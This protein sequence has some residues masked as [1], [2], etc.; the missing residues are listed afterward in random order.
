[1]S[2]EEPAATVGALASRLPFFWRA[3]PEI[4]FVQIEAHF[5]RRGITSQRTKFEDVIS[6]L[7]PE[8][9]VEVR[10]I[11]LNPPEEEPYDMLKNQL[12]HQVAAAESQ[13]IQQLL[14]A[15]ELG[16]RK[17]TQLLRK[18]Q[19]LLGGNGRNAG[20]L[21]RELFLQRLPANVRMVLAAAHESTSVEKLAEMADRVVE[22]MSPTVSA[23]GTS[24]AAGQQH[25]T[26]QDFTRREDHSWAH[27]RTASW[28]TSS[29]PWI[30][31]SR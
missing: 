26:Q 14:T 29:R 20:T 27:P 10:D 19:Q 15:E 5:A 16:D 12:I 7:A 11:L 6:S 2:L 22:M 3:D 24:I 25:Q 4:W 13:R 21:L 1:M 28:G 8:Y 31:V 18:M 9:A 17:P 30:H 23:V